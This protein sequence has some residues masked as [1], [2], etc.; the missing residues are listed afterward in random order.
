MDTGKHSIYT[1]YPN[2][3]LWN[4]GAFNVETIFAT[5]ATATVAIEQNNAP[6]SYDAANGRTN[7]TQ[8][9]VDAY[10]MRTT[11]RFITD[12]ASGYNAANPYT[13]RDPRFGFSVLFNTASVQP[14]VAA[15][16][17]K[18]KPVE[19]FVGGKDG[20]NLNVNATKT[21]YYM[22]KFLSESASWPVHK[23]QFVD[24]GFFIAMQ[25]YC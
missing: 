13:N 5:S 18:T 11:G 22:R 4:S 23:L 17:F 16:S 19:T 12:G 1:S 21:G 2:L 6:V 20:L 10:E 14:L 9:Q 3:W 24:L 15:N 7:P 25:K 8:E